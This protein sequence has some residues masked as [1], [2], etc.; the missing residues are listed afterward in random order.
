MNGGSSPSAPQPSP[1]PEAEVFYA[2]AYQRMV[3]TMLILP[4]LILPV[5]LIKFHLA[6]ALGFVAGSVIAFFNFYWLK[7]AVVALGDRATN[8]PHRQSGSRVV[9]GFFMRYI[10]IVVGAYVIF[11]SSAMSGYG[12]FVGLFVPVG[13]VLIEAV[14]ETYGALR[15]GF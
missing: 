12:L 3:R 14:V 11:K 1:S 8:S 9:A 5:L 15:R 2:R 10:L 4:L 13:A 6:M 7:R